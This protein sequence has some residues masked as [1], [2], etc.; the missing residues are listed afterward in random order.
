MLV[1]SYAKSNISNNTKPNKKAGYKR[2][3]SKKRLNLP[4]PLAKLSS[5]KKFLTLKKIRY[6]KIKSRTTKVSRAKR[7]VQNITV[8]NFFERL[9]AADTTAIRLIGMASLVLVTGFVLINI[10]TENVQANFSQD[11]PYAVFYDNKTTLDKKLKDNKDLI[12]ELD[13]QTIDT[14]KEVAKTK[15]YTVQAGDTLNKICTNINVNCEAL[16]DLNAIDPYNMQVGQE[17]TLPKQIR[18]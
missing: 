11:D 13:S 4:N 15:T 5:A 7:A 12:E 17:L 16:I 3:S 2:A 10:D 14:D 9:I 6:R 8:P 18:E 1:K